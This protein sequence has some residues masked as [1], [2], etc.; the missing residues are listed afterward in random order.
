MSA[1]AVN[2]IFFSV[3]GESTH[4]GLPC[5]FV[6]LTG[7]NLRCVW[8][9][10]A[11]AFHEGKLMSLGEILDA[12]RAF[13]CRRVEVTG[14]EPLIQAGVPD[15]L[16]ALCDENYQT[17]LETGGS[18]DI[19]TVDP[20]VHRIVDIKCPGSGMADRNLWSNIQ[21]LKSGDEVKFVVRDH[22]D[23]DWACG[24]IQRH[25]LAER[26]SVLISG[27]FGE[28][29]LADLARWILESGIDSR[30]QIQLHKII[31]EPSLRGV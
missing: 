24:V 23:F 6:R 14:G 21:H 13:P 20:R 1:L 18:L 11:Y 5:V 27:V 26:C 30:L 2:E 29:P 19:S 17:L 28:V 22:A 10:T 31:W 3:Q 7:C 12:V 4:T 15:L 25:R 16:R 9:D 8:C